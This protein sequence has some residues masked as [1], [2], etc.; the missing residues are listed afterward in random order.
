MAK[1]STFSD[2]RPHPRS[3]V[4]RTL[5][6]VFLVSF[7][8]S[9]SLRGEPLPHPDPGLDRPYKLQVVLHFAENRFFTP[10]FQEHVERDLRELLQQNYG[11]L[12]AVEVVRKHPRLRDVMVKGLQQGLDGWEDLTEERTHFVLVDYA[13]GHYELRTRVHDG[14]TGLN[15]PVVRTERSHD[16][17]QVSRLAALLVDRDFGLAGTVIERDKDQARLALQGGKRGVDLGRW[18][19]KG[20]VFAV[21]RLHGEGGKARATP[22]HWAVLQALE[23]PRD[24]TCRC[25]F[26]HRFQQDHLEPAAGL[27]G[28]RAFQLATIAAPVKLRLLDDQSFRPLDG[29]QVHVSGEGYSGK[30][31]LTTNAEGLAS[32][33]ESF[34]NLAFVRI[35]SGNGMLAQFPIPLVDDRAIVCR[36]RVAPQAAPLQALEFR[37][38]LWLRRIYDQLLAGN[39]RVHEMDLLV[40]KSLEGALSRARQNAKILAGELA[41]LELERVQLKRQ[42]A[43][44]KLPDA[45]LDLREGDHRLQ[46]LRRRE[47]RLHEFI[48]RLEIAIKEGTSEKTKSMLQMVERAR[49]LEH[50]TEIDQAI[51]LYEKVLA[52]DPGQDKVRQ[53]LEALKKAWAVNDPE[54]GKAREFIFKVWPRTEV[55]GLKAVVPDARKAFEACRRNNDHITP[56]KLLAT[57]LQH[58]GNLKKRLETLKGR[59]TEDNRAEGRVL[60]GVAQE[61]MQLHREVIAF[62]GPPKKAP[63]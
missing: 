41:G 63:E 54:H 58:I 13:N 32:T 49:L 40:A 46:E 37:K 35:L 23:P 10:V 43:E 6:L 16:R 60:I 45:K 61:L 15:S 21:V 28:Y 12:A 27:L 9:P 56:R 4:L 2:K 19:K 1:T 11:P 52:D 25:R 7:L 36:L 48:G 8:C 44:L 47:K 31:E 50:H 14:M 20:D 34:A 55:S 59:D 24:G 57:H 38:D 18:L 42:A 26:F 33:K 3:A 5:H 62:L 53:H 51:A 17:Q 29:L 22:M 39:E 30:R